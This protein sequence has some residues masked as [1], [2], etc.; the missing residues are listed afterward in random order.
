MNKNEIE[1]IK[2][3]KKEA[4]ANRQKYTGN[5]PEDQR[6]FAYYSGE[7]EAYRTVLLLA[8]KKK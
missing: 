2:K 5:K 3:L 8:K 1:K 6:F 4:W 7:V